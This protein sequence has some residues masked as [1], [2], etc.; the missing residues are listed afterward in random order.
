MLFQWGF[1]GSVHEPETRRPKLMGVRAL[2]YI[3]L[4]IQECDTNVPKRANNV[5]CRM[6]EHV[7]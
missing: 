2:Y 4:Q 7:K 6:P 3:S 1:V 5:K